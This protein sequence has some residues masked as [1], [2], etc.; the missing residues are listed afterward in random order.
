[1]AETRSLLTNPAI[2]EAMLFTILLAVGII[3]LPVAIFLVGE[4][5]FG[6]YGGD[7]FG[8][9]LESIF[10][11]LFDGDRFAWFLIL[12]PYIVVQLLRVLGLAWRATAAPTEP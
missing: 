8:Q 1:M 5:V 10:T 2:R 7:G 12:S 11:R 4:V 6:D 3:L 9:F